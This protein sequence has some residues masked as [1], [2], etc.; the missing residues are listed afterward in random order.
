[1]TIVAP[2]A[3]GAISSETAMSNDGVVTASTTSA[4]ASPGSRATLVR[5]LTTLRCGTHAL[6]VPVEPEV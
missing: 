2:T 3:S 1:M 6:G 4:S 5:R